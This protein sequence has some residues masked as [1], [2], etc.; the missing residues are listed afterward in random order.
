MEEK[1]VCLLYR[2]WYTVSTWG[3]ESEKVENGDLAPLDVS[4]HGDVFPPDGAGAEGGTDVGEGAQVVVVPVGGVV[5]RTELF[6]G[7]PAPALGKDDL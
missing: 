7:E 3:K 2:L 4:A 1:L 5:R 6:H